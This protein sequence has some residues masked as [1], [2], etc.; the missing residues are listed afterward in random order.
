MRNN[1]NLWAEFENDSKPT[2][3]PKKKKKRKFKKPKARIFY[4]YNTNK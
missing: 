4:G 2:I 1:S 3:K